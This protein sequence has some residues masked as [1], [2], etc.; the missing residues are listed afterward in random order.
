MEEEHVL[1][2]WCQTEIVWDEEIGPEKHCPH[3][4]NELS[5]YRTVQFGIHSEEESDEEEQ[6]GD[7]SDWETEGDDEERVRVSPDIAELRQYGLER[8]ALESTM[9]RILDDQLEAPECPSCREFMLESGTMTVTEGQFKP[10]TPAP[11]S[12][13]LLAPPFQIV[14]YVCPSCFHTENRL[15][16]Q[17]QERFVQL[18]A[19]AAEE[20]G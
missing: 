6:Q 19:S 18:L 2:P 3:C 16:A 9:E 20:Q 12:A 10:R 8:L 13:P 4:E 5:G 7:D 11:L 14:L 1:C 17:D 15:A